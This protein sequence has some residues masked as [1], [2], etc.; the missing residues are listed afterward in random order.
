MTKKVFGIT[1]LL[2][3]IG[4]GS[5]FAQSKPTY[6][7]SIYS[8]TFSS[9]EGWSASG[10]AGGG[11]VAEGDVFNA[12]HKNNPGST[13]ITNFGPLP[14]GRYTITGYHHTITENTIIL[15]PEFS[16]NRTLLRIHGD[17][18][19]N[20]GRASRGCIVIGPNERQKIVDAFNRH[21][22]LTLVVHE[23]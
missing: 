6:Y 20:P 3:V 16:T 1:L 23:Y 19:S 17:S 9:S 10:Y 4:V 11:S 13:S 22:Q 12:T 2:L 21:G 5:V 15:R 14:A 7:Y 8:G 18:R